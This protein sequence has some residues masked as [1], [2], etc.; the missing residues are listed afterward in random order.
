MNNCKV[1]LE[2]THKD[3]KIPSKN[4]DSDA[5]YDL[6]SVENITIPAGE[7]VVVPIGLKM[8]C[9]K[10][11]YY[12]FAPRSGLAFNKNLV[13]SHYNVMDAYFSGDASPLLYNRSNKDIEIKKGDK[14]CQVLFK[15]TTDVEFVETTDVNENDKRGE[16]GFGSSGR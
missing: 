10:G 6:Y 11:W 8:V 7:R 4:Y 15:Q 13:V 5:G 16:N 2:L 3:A 14:V 9:E 1:K 12:M